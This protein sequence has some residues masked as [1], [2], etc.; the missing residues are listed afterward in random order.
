[1]TDREHTLD[2]E[3]AAE[4]RAASAYEREH[5]EWTAVEDITVDESD[6]MPEILAEEVSEAFDVI[7]EPATLRR[8]RVGTD[9]SWAF[10]EDRS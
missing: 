7:T 5:D 3:A 8:I 6:F 10:E 4:L 9:L 1:M 2:V